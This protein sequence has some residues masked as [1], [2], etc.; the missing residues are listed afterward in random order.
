MNY[1]FPNLTEHPPRSP[2]VRLGGYV[3]LPRCLDKCRDFRRIMLAIGIEQIDG[4]QVGDARQFLQIFSKRHL[5]P[6]PFGF[7]QSDDQHH[8]RD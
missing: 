5:F 8:G 2:R 3:I 7:D 1:T 6:F 4:G